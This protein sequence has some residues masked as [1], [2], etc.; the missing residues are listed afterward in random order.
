R[1]L[2]Q[3]H[4]GQRCGARPRRERRD[5]G[6]HSLASALVPL[7]GP[8]ARRGVA[9]GWWGRLGG[10]RSLLARGAQLLAAGRAPLLGGAAR[11][12]VAAA[13]RP[14]WTRPHGGLARR[15][16]RPRGGLV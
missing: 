11:R 1:R 5:R 8:P 14:F 13:R 10:V 7:L 15:A 2:S 9:T 16:P 3:E 4:P 6:V 12:G